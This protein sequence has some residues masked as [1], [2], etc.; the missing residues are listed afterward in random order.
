MAGA[1]REPGRVGGGAASTLPGRSHSAVRVA[2][3]DPEQLRRVLEQVTR[4]Q[5][6]PSAL[7]D[8]R[9]LRDAA[10]QA[11]PQRGPGAEAP[12]LLL[13]QVRRRGWRGPEAACAAGVR[14]LGVAH[15]THPGR[16][17]WPRRSG[18]SRAPGPLGDVRPPAS[19]APSPAPSPSA[20]PD[21]RLVFKEHY[22]RF[23][24]RAERTSQRR[25]ITMRRGG[26][27]IASPCQ[28]VSPEELR[29]ATEGRLTGGREE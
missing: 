23:Y 12:R 26:G 10:Q 4:A 2:P 21:L 19:S 9:R 6:P 22:A 20:P 3:L 18:A 13:P 16:D 14:N 1:E 11:A 5:P 15:H 27:A 7:Q 25:S 17:P 24:T 8:A 29:Q 28:R